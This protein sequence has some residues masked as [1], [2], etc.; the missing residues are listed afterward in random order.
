M[1]EFFLHHSYFDPAHDNPVLFLVGHS[2][3]VFQFIF[4][5]LAVGDLMGVLFIA[6]VVFLLRGSALIGEETSSQRL[7]IFLILPFTVA[8]VAS[9]AHLYPYGGTRHLA[10]LIIPGIAGV[11]IAAVR[12]AREKRSRSLAFSAIVIFFCIAFGKPRLPR[13]DRADQSIAHMKTAIE[14]INRNAKPSDLILTDYQGDL[15]LG[16]YLC[17]QSPIAIVSSATDFEEFSCAGHRVVS[18]NY[19][20]AWIF[21]ADGFPA[22]WEEFLRAY[23]LRPGTN[24]WVVQMGWEVAL[25]EDLRKKVREFHDLSFESFGNNI[26]IFERTVS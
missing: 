24:V 10:F 5:Q 8:A 6:A 19:K 15:I 17:R 13:M 1:S 7:G 20:T 3:G 11:S 12:L 4:G 14:F 21:L 18:A 23:N 2:F 22:N 26:K 9:L 16:H 25:P